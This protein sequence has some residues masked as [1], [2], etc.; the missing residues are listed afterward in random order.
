MSHESDLIS[1]VQKRSSLKAWLLASRPE[2]LSVAFV[3]LLVGTTLASH[4]V[5]HLNW[6]LV[7]STFL[8]VP[9]I[10]IGMNLVNDALDFKKGEKI[11]KKLNLQR[12]GLLSPQ[13]ALKGGYVCFGLTLFFG[14]PLILAGGWPFALLLLISIALAYLYTGGPFPLS[15]TGTSESFILIFYGWVSTAAVYYLQTGK[16]EESPLL[17]GT[18]TGL[19]AIV[20]HAINNLRDRVADALVQK[21]TLAVRWGPRFARWEISLCSFIPFLLGLLW[22]KEGNLWMAALPFL[23]LSLVVRNMRSIWQTE[24]GPHYNQFLAQSALCQLIF[25]CLLA[26]GSFL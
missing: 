16:I 5:E 13:Q 7:I 25:G 11:V 22:I 19:L 6:I 9:W 24:P 21:K 12:T 26:V 3:S 2:T 15:Y 4:Q 8:C 1:H 10:Q 18:Q 17:A 14:I 20:P 23:S